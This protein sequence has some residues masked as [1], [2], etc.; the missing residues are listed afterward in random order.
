MEMLLS[1]TKTHSNGQNSLPHSA[2]VKWGL[3]EMIIFCS[4]DKEVWRADMTSWLEHLNRHL[5]HVMETNTWPF[6][7]E[8]LP[9]KIHFHR[10]DK[11]LQKA[12]LTEHQPCTVRWKF[13]REMNIHNVSFGS[14]YSS[15]R[16]CK[17]A[18]V[19]KTQKSREHPGSRLS[20]VQHLGED[21]SACG[22]PA[23][24]WEGQIRPRRLS[25]RNKTF[26]QCFR[27]YGKQNLIVEVRP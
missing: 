20:S 12:N 10:I 11:C 18:K 17:I 15:P 5:M 27:V 22:E 4:Q 7:T 19:K 3:R 8:G 26:P 9:G 6:S 16:R 2:H 25:G 23:N 14:T 1:I 13:H 24:A 21:R